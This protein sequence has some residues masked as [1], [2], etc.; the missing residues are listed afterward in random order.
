MLWLVYSGDVKIRKSTI[1][2]S[3]GLGKESKRLLF[4]KNRQKTF[5]QRGDGM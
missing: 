5:D 2:A 4:A 1:Q 3:K